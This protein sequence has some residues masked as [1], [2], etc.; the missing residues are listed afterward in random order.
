MRSSSKFVL[1]VV[2]ALLP[3]T[4]FA[5]TTKRKT[6]KKTAPKK[7]AVTATPQPTPETITET[8]P[9]KNEREND[10]K[11]NSRDTG[12]VATKAQTYEPVYVYTFDRPGFVYSNIK[13]EHDDAGKGRIWFKKDNFDPDTSGLD[14]P[15]ELS[16]ATV[17]KLKGAFSALNFIDSTEDY[18][19]SKDFS[20]M[21]NVT[22]TLNRT[23][24]TRTAKYNWTENKHAKSLM[25]TYRAIANE[26][27]WKFEFALARENQ[28]LFT[29]SLIDALDGYLGRNEIADPPHLLPFLTQISTDERLPLMARNRVA[30]IIAKIE[31]AAAE[32]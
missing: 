26:Y 7:P 19:Y 1:C 32:K 9:K 12:A 14:D 28:P 24:K 18:Q 4:L 22:I 20:N 11:T 3:L 10:G 13:I 2:I 30:K 31:K 23:G 17:E 8:P 21:G 29:P 25:D 5:Q 16:A 15:I 27:T 6:T